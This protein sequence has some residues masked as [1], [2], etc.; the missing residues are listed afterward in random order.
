M[1]RGSDKLQ[2]VGKLRDELRRL[3]E[4]A[5][6]E[7]QLAKEAELSAEA[8]L[9]GESAAQERFTDCSSRLVNEYREHLDETSALESEA[10]RYRKELAEIR[11][12]NLELS[13][14]NL[15]LDDQD[16]YLRKRRAELEDLLQRSKDERGGLDA[17]IKQKRD[18][19]EAFGLQEAELQQRLDADELR[20]EDLYSKIRQHQSGVRVVALHQ[21]SSPETQGQKLQFSR[22]IEDVANCSLALPSPVSAE[23][24]SF[25]AN[26][27]GQSSLLLHLRPSS[28][29]QQT[30]YGYN[31]GYAPG[32]LGMVVDWA[33]EQGR[34][35]AAVYGV[36]AGMKEEPP[37]LRSIFSSAQ[38]LQLAIEQRERGDVV[39]RLYITDSSAATLAE[40]V[41]CDVDTS[42]PEVGRLI[43]AISDV[44]KV[45]TKRM[46]KDAP[47]LAK[48]P[49]WLQAQAG[50]TLASANGA[51]ASSTSGVAAASTSMLK[52][53]NSMAMAFVH[54]QPGEERSPIAQS[55]VQWTSVDPRGGSASTAR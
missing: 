1:T 35:E 4:Q 6:A 7:E 8:A 51:P 45:G 42:G 38:L 12:K 25:L 18:A 37:A 28:E 31:N 5:A 29:V 19:A 43:D 13:N 30:F 33:L 3:Q 44:G 55:V 50:A 22:V 11:A 52:K 36:A 54:L 53:P 27:A 34:T 32:I 39:V 2:Q 9:A 15:E 46:K 40:I 21:R 47:I 17:E 41:I 23:I 10:Q 16:R 48:L 24:Q 49:P 20:F 14:Q 26:A